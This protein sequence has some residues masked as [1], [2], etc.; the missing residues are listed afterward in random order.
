VEGLARQV[1]ALQ[2]AVE[3]TQGA[4]DIEREEIEI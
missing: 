1:E 3:T 4:R 2:I